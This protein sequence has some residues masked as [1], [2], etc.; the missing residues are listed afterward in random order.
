MSKVHAERRGLRMLT[1][2]EGS[3]VHA[4]RVENRGLDAGYSCGREKARYG[5]LVG[6]GAST[7]DA[8]VERKGLRT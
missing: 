3:Q 1:A 4:A 8:P 5:L 7:P 2:R 6:R